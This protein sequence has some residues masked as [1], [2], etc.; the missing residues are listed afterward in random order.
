MKNKKKKQDREDNRR[1][2]IKGNKKG[3][4]TEIGK[5][6]RDSVGRTFPL[7]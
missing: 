3:L 1:L 5:K 4:V 6:K 2:P 7:E